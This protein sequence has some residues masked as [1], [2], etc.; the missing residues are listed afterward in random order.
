MVYQF[1]LASL[2]F[3]RYG[4]LRFARLFFSC[5]KVD[6]YSSSDDGEESMGN[7]ENMPLVDHD[8]TTAFK[9]VTSHPMRQIGGKAKTKVHSL[10]KLLSFQARAKDCLLQLFDFRYCFNQNSR[11]FSRCS[12]LQLLKQECCF[13]SLVARIGVEQTSRQHLNSLTND[14]CY[15]TLYYRAAL[16][17]SAA[18]ESPVCEQAF[19]II[20]EFSEKMEVFKKSCTGIRS[21]TNGPW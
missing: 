9:I 11:Q 1:N 18:K 3:V 14:R 21:W 12:C 20:M 5:L 13:V 17:H 15:R 2:Y 16:C 8:T 6:E 10:V 7:N 4:V 19:K